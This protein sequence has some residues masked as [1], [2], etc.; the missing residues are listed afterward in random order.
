MSLVLLNTCRRVWC[1]CGVMLIAS[2]TLIP[3]SAH[4]LGLQLYSVRHQ[5][6]KDVDATFA[7]INKW[8]LTLV[9]GG[10][11]LYGHS[12]DNY[13]NFLLKNN[14][15]MAS[16][17]ASYEELRDNPIAVVYKARFFGS[18]FATF[19]WIPHDGS[20]PFDFETAKNAVT[21]MNKA[22][23]LLKQHGITL[24]YHPHGY[25]FYAYEDGTLLDYMIQNTHQA[26][27]QMDVFWMK[28]GGMDPTALLQ[29]YPGR[30]TSLHL[31]DRL[32]GTANTKNGSGDN[33]SN[34]VLGEGD[35]GIAKVVAEA[36][37]QGIRYF[38]LEDE[39]SRV[40]EQIPKSI[41][42]LHTLDGVIK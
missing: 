31:K 35:V 19:Y 13:R 29:K 6:E 23:L 22:G 26:Q 10:G 20:K 39:S 27:F 25:E 38:F 3:L 16:V 2:S 37:K 1:I 12:I 30:F 36:K 21:M 24:Q 7:E 14:L 17:D 4:E 41:D 8:G 40:M 15:E 28:Q 42:F 11:A 5:M 18:R 9:E 32:K 33:E 34:V